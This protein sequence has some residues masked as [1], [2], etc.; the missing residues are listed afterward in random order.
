M[1]FLATIG[2]IFIVIIFYVTYKFIREERAQKSKKL[3]QRVLAEMALGHYNEAI[4]IL[5]T[6]IQ[7]RGSWEDYN[8]RGT[9]YQNAGK[10]QWAL[11]DYNKSIELQPDA[12]INGGSYVG[13]EEMRAKLKNVK[14]DNRN[15]F[16][17]LRDE[18]NL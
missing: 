10:Y 12:N 1:N 4:T 16:S 3:F 7:Q 17:K 2:L 15:Y 14:P 18:Y 8:L 9:L 5:N 11:N 13:R 6:L